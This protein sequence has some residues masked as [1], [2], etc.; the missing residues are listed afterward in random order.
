[1]SPTFE[2]EIQRHLESGERLIWRG[3]PLGRSTVLRELLLNLNG[4]TVIGIILLAVWLVIETRRLIHE[5]WVLLPMFGV[6]LICLNSWKRKSE[7][8]LCMTDNRL[9]VIDALGNLLSS[10]ALQSVQ[11]SKND[12]DSLIIFQTQGKRVQAWTCS[13]THEQILAIEKELSS[14]GLQLAKDD[15]G[16]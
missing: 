1:M 13:S 6:F 15:W 14:R 5:P 11:I 16:W 10:A 12:L 8:V 9:L 7:L 2:H 3:H 4:L